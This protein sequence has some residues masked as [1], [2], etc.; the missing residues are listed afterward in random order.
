VRR[1]DDG[2]DTFVAAYTA[3]F[4]TPDC[5]GGQE[6]I[7]ALAIARSDP[8]TV[9]AAG[10]DQPDWAPNRAVVVRTADDGVS[11]DAFELLPDWSEVYAIAVAPDDPETA[12]AGGTDCSGASCVGFLMRTT[13]GGQTWGSRQET[14]YGTYS[15]AV[16][17]HRPGVAY[18]ADGGYYV[19]KSIDWGETWNSIRQPPDPS[20]ALLAVD[21]NMADHLYLSGRNFFAESADGGATWNAWNDPIGNGL[22]QFEAQSIA[23]DYG[24]GTQNLYAGFTGVW[25]YTRQAPAFRLYLP[26]VLRGY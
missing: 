20:G 11:W 2:G 17:A 4:I 5:N 26:M 18:A 15:I 25:S 23:V 9:Y 3:P 6:N 14:A 19:Y 8:R 1:S 24:M 21:P 10:S 12:Y 13:D 7:Y 22:P 16:D